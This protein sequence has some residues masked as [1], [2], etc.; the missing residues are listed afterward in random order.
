MVWNKPLVAFAKRHHLGALQ[1]APHA[2]GVFFLIHTQPFPLRPVE[3]RA[4]ERTLLGGVLKAIWDR[5]RGVQD[6]KPRAAFA[7]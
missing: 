2:F 7:P 1:E 6:L 5:I 3:R 4:E